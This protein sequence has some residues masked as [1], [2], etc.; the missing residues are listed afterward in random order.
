MD[1]NQ[2]K[3]VKRLLGAV[4][5]EELFSAVALGPT[6][7]PRVHHKVVKCLRRAVFL[8]KLSSA[9]AGGPTRYLRVMTYPWLSSLQRLYFDTLCKRE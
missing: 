3:L 6:R 8:G 1:L 7:Y 9:V 4:C 2:N 5:L